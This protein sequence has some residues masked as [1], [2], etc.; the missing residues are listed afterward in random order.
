MDKK[1]EKEVEYYNAQ[2]NRLWTGIIVLGGGL[3]GLLLTYSYYSPI[4]AMTNMVRLILFAL[5]FIF[6]IMMIIGI[7]NIST[8]IKNF[9]K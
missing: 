5:G 2:L 3:S 9:L 7:I 4:Y 1:E 6:F 8:D